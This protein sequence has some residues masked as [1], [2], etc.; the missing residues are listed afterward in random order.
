MKTFVLIVFLTGTHPQYA[1]NRAFSDYR[2]CLSVAQDLM[3]ADHR[4]TAAC[5]QF[6]TGKGIGHA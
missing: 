6:S 1:V 2:I 5:Y 4:L 3:Q